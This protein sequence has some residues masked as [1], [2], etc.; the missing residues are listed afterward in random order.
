MRFQTALLAAVLTA[1]PL[2]CSSTSSAPSASSAPLPFAGDQ[3]RPN[4]RERM[5][6]DALPNSRFRIYGLWLDLALLGVP[7][8]I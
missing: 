7:H 5:L 4:P 3:A 1:M 2:A 8:K 6:L